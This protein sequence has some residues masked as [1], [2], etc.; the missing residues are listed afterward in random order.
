MNDDLIRYYEESWE[1]PRDPRDHIFRRLNR[2]VAENLPPGRGKKA[3]DVGSGRGTIVSYLR[4]KGYRV[5]ALDLNGRFL[6]EIKCRYPD[7]ECVEGD[8]CEVGLTGRFDLV[9]AIEFI[10]NLDRRSLARFFEKA[11]GLTDHLLFN[12]SNR[13][14]LHGFWACRRGFIKNFV[15]V[16]TPAEI[17]RLLPEHGFDVVSRRGVGLLTPITLLSGFR[18]KIIPLWLAR[19]VNRPGERIFPR[20]C[21]LYFIEAK[22]GRKEELKP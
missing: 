16:Y 6:Q 4:E 20:A 19:S 14:S 10:Q 1:N 11:A 3:L 15:H 21:H 18:V 7:V 2:V 22:K 8:F 9:T 13:R 17:E 12:I 5:T